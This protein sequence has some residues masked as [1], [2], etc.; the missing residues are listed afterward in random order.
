MIV[1]TLHRTSRIRLLYHAP[2][3]FVGLKAAVDP[4]AYQCFMRMNPCGY[5]QGKPVTS[6]AALREQPQQ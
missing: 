6:R 5:R 2:G 4:S 1:D 3:L